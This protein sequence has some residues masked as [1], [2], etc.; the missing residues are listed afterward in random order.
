MSRFEFLAPQ[1]G[2]TDLQSSRVVI[3]PAPFERSTSYVRGAAG[4]PEAILAASCQVEEYDPRL[5]R[6]TTREGIH[7]ADPVADDTTLPAEEYLGRLRR[8]VRGYLDL[9]KLVVTLGGEHTCSLAPW[10]AHQ[11]HYPGLGILQLDAHADLR[12]SYEGD[13]FSHASV[14]RRILETRPTAAVA[15]GIR[16]MCDEEA[17]LYAGGAVTLVDAAT[18]AADSAWIER[19]IAPLPEQV[20]VTLD[21]DAFDPSIIPATGTP[22]PG[23]LSWYQML[24]LLDRL[25]R[26]RRVVGFDLVELAPIDGL[27]YP[28]FTCAKLVYFFLGMILAR[29]R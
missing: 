27:V 10:Q 14:M 3:L 16:S 8:A 24:A 26:T 2:P 11:E 7:T 28:D 29:G 20:Y 25:T 18:V 9:G 12:E 13:R 15:V 4:G 1:A 6:L 17:A 21:V 19:A 5:G 23:G 22:E